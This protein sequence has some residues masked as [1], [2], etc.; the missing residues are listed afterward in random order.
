MIQ[1][2]NATLLIIFKSEGSFKSSYSYCKNKRTK[3]WRKIKVNKTIVINILPI[4]KYVE[5]VWDKE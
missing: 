3:V 1:K 5:E 2:H 4:S